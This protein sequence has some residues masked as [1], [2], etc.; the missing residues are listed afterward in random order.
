ML[1]YPFE[2]K[3]L[4][5]WSPPYLV[6]PK[7][8]GERC[9]A[10]L[11]AEGVQLLS[12]E[13]NEFVSVP[14]VVSALRR[15]FLQINKPVELDGELYS[16]G[17]SFEQIHSI[18]S[19]TRNLHEDH[20]AISLHVFDLVYEEL[21]QWERLR[22]LMEMEPF[23]KGRVTLVP[24]KVAETLEQILRI[25]DEYLEEGYEGIVVRHF[26]STYV[27]RRST[28][29][30]KFKPKKSDSYRIVDVK[31]MIDKDGKPKEMLGALICSGDDGTEFS[32]G[33]GMTDVFRM[34][35]WPMENALQLV[36][37]QA[38]VQY[39]HITPGRGVPRFPVL[40][41]VEEPLEDFNPLL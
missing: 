29:L 6:Q 17:Y 14:L 19:R 31:Q 38:V 39:Q 28:F 9:R 26:D 23:F 10:I 5:K 22:L 36:G 16:H 24:F 4:E 20:G 18:V 41:S 25:Y 8:D 12:S 35:N 15:L 30:M 40:V 27:R 32:V 3:R 1:C 13:E 33:S 37:K 7:L 34:R 2:E 21:P 11:S